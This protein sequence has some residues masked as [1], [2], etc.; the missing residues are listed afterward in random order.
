MNKDKIVKNIQEF[1]CGSVIGHVDHGKTTLTAALTIAAAKF[2]PD[3][4]NEVR[5]VQKI[6]HAPEEKKRG[7]TIVAT[8]VPIRFEGRE[9]SLSDCPGHEDYIRN[10]IIGAKSSDFGILVIAGTEG[11]APQTKQHVELSAILGINRMFVVYNKMDVEEAQELIDLVKEEVNDLL[12]ENNIEQLGFVELS[13]TKAVSG[14]E[15]QLNKVHEILEFMR[16]FDVQEILAN[17][18]FRVVISDVHNP[19]GQGTIVSGKVASGQISKNADV[20]I[21][22]MNMPK[23][24]GSILKMETFRQEV[25][26]GKRGMDLGMQIRG[27]TKTNVK[28][29][30]T[31]V[32]KGMAY[33]VSTFRGLFQIVDDVKQGRRTPFKVG[34]EPQCFINE[35]GISITCVVNQIFGAEYAKPGD[36]IE[37]SI[38]L[39]KP[40]MI[41]EQG[42]VFLRESNKTVGFGKIVSLDESTKKMG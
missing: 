18:T 37:L 35:L 41:F 12:K 31:I 28:K 21:V 30:M 5:D 7:I 8:H 32:Q 9:V 27:I 17:E 42:G 40:V 11:V 38:Q 26:I 14:D 6:D 39:Y 2:Y 10:M 15:E 4:G 23:V 22:G 16:T 33:T 19:K 34:F 25:P 20:E 13:A 3:A 36:L 24:L 29:G 1:L